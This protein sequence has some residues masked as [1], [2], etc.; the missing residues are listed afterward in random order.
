MRIVVV[1]P[2]RHGSHSG[3]RV[4]AL[5]WAAHLRA[6]GHRVAVS[7][8]WEGEPCDL[9][10]ALHATKSHASA[11]RFRAARPDAPLVVGPRWKRHRTAARTSAAR[12]GSWSR[13]RAPVS[14]R[15]RSPSIH[16]SGATL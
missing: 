15:T 16:P 7:G 8:A 14:A 6:L 10:V 1:T 3:N 4:T 5:R 9:L 11:R 2:A 13:G 12:S